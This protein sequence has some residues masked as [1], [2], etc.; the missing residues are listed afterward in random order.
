MIDQLTF[1]KIWGYSFMFNIDKRQLID[2]LLGLAI[3]IGK[4]WLKSLFFNFRLGYPSE[5][6]LFL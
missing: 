4:M 1:H 2:K 6:S 3:F 5:V